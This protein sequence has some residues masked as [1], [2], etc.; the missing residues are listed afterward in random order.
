MDTL[1]TEAHWKSKGLP[2]RTLKEKLSQG[3]TGISEALRALA[4]ADKALRA[5]LLNS[6]L[7][8]KMD[9]VL[10]AT[11]VVLKKFK[12]EDKKLIALRDDMIKALADYR[13]Q[14]N[15]LLLKLNRDNLGGLPGG[16]KMLQ[17]QAE[18][19]FSTENQ[20]FV[21]AAMKVAGDATKIMAFIESINV[22]D[23]NISNAGRW[24]TLA[25]EHAAWEKQVKLALKTSLTDILNNQQDTLTRLKNDCLL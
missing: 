13:V 5:E 19:E 8:K 24:T 2:L 15:A 23:L 17:K 6:A 14:H 4:L 11:D 3:K 1:L 25:N 7:V 18:K 12:A 9:T 20:E 22:G 10:K 16:L 21:T